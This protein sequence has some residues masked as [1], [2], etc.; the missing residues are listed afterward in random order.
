MAA[1]P[2]L[3][4]PRPGFWT[5]RDASVIAKHFYGGGLQYSDLYERLQGAAYPALLAGLAMFA[6]SADAPAGTDGDAVVLDLNPPAHSFDPSTAIRLPDGRTIVV[7][8]RH[9]IIDAS[10]IKTCFVRRDGVPLEC[11]TLTRRFTPPP[12][13]PPATFAN[14]AY[15]APGG[16]DWRWQLRLAREAARI[17]MTLPLRASAE[18]GPRTVR[19][20]EEG[21]A[22]GAWRVAAVRGVPHEIDAAGSAVVLYPAEGVTGEVRFSLELMKIHRP[23]SMS[24]WPPPW[25]EEPVATPRNAPR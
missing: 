16:S 19:L 9:F 14:L 20:I 18:D 15:P 4:I 25:V 1:G 10:E 7:R 17:E 5:M 21:G 6:P 11:R 24:P 3:T 8:R 13:P 2:W 22:P 23:G 12:P